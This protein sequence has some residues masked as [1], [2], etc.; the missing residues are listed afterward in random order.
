[1]LNI[2]PV[3]S[4]HCLIIALLSLLT[5]GLFNASFAA[6][7]S[8]TISGGSTPLENIKVSLL[9][10]NQQLIPNVSTVTTDVTGTYNFSDIAEGM[11]FITVTAPSNSLYSDPTPSQITLA[12]DNQTL[13][14][15]LSLKEVLLEGLVH[16]GENN[17]LIGATITVFEK[18]G[19]SFQQRGEAYTVD[20]FGRYQ[21]TL[22]A[23]QYFLRSNVRNSQSTREGI[24][25]F[26]QYSSADF[27]L[28]QNTTLDIEFPFVAISG[29]V[30]DA[31]GLP[32]VGAQLTT[33]KGWQ[34]PSQGPS[35]TLEQRSLNHLNES[36]VTNSN[37]EYTLL[38]YPSDLCIDAAFF[39]DPNDCLYDI[40]VVPPANSGFSEQQQI[41][42]EVFE[43][44]NLNFVLGMSS[45]LAPKIVAGPFAESISDSAATITWRSDLASTGVVNITGLGQFTSDQ[46]ATRHQV[47]VNSL[48]ANSSYGYTVTATNEAGLSSA[49]HSGSFTT[50]ATPDTLPP[51]FITSPALTLI[52][53]TSV[54]IHF[55]ANEAVTGTI[56]LLNS[57]S[58][59]SNSF[60]LDGYNTCFDTRI[61]QLTTNTA[62]SFVVSITDLAE[63]GPTQS[64]ERVFK[65]LTQTDTIAPQIITGPFVTNISNRSALVRWTTDEPATSGVTLTKGSSHQVITDSELTREHTVLFSSLTAASEYSV[66]VTSQDADGNGPSV[67]DSLTFSTKSIPDTT[68]PFILGQPLVLEVTSTTATILWRS[69]E[70][71]TGVI[72]LG[73]RGESR[74]TVFSSTSI[75]N[76]HNVAVT[77]LSA[78]TQYDFQVEVTDLAGLTTQSQILSFKTPV[79]DIRV[80][81]EI[82]AGPTVERVTHNSL[83]VSWRTATP[84][85]PRLVCQAN[86]QIREVEKV[87]LATSHRLTISG[88]E[89]STGYQ[90]SIFATDSLGLSTNANFA[91]GTRLPIADTQSPSCTAPPQ[92]AGLGLSAEVTWESDEAST[93]VIHWR[94][95]SDEQWSEVSSE[96]LTTEHFQ[97]VS[98]LSSNTEYDVLIELTDVAG[99]TGTCGEGSF[100]SGD[101]QPD[102]VFT[103]A[104]TIETVDHESAVVVWQTELNSTGQI[105]Y[106]L[107][108]ES[109]DL[110]RASDEASRNHRSKLTKLIANTTYYLRVIAANSEGDL[111]ESAVISFTTKALPPVAPTLLAGPNVVD[112]TDSS[113]VVEWQTDKATIGLVEIEGIGQFENF[114]STTQHQI[115][116]N[117]LAPSTT[118]VASVIATD[119]FGLSCERTSVEFTTSALPDTTAPVF[120]SGPALSSVATTSAVVDFCADEPVTGQLILGDI[121]FDLDELK[122]CHTINLSGLQQSTQYAFRCQIR[123]GAG[124]GPTESQSLSFTTQTF[125]DTTAPAILA[126]PIVSQITSQSAIVTW[127]TSEA[128]SSQV[129]YSDGVS[130]WQVAENNGVTD[131]QILL[132]GLSASTTYSLTVASSDRLGN[133]PTVSEAV[134]FTTLG[135]PDTAAPQIIFGPE[136]QDITLTS[137]YVIWETNEAATSLVRFGLSA[138]SLDLSVS[139]GD[140]K[141]SHKLALTQLSPATEYFGQVESKDAAGNAAQSEV[142][143]FKTLTPVPGLPVIPK[144][145]IIDG[146]RIDKVTH[147]SMT[148]S[149]ETNVNTDSR[150]VC[151]R[152]GNQHET[153]DSEKAQKHQLTLSGL[154][155][156]TRYQCEVFSTDIHQQTVSATLAGTCDGRPDTTAPQ[157]LGPVEVLSFEDEA[158][159]TWTSDEIAIATI[160]YR[161]QG[162]SE[163]LEAS[164]LDPVT[165]GYRRLSDLATTTTY[166]LQVQLSDQSGNKA[167]C[168]VSTFLSGG[169]AVLPLCQFTIQP[170][171]SNIGHYS[172]EVNWTTDSLSTGIVHF[173]LASSELD[174]REA[175]NETSRNH[176]VAL[177]SLTPNTTYYVQVEARNGQGEANFSQVVAFTT[178]APEP[179]SDGDTIPEPPVVTIPVDENPEDPVVIEFDNCP[180][181]ANEDQLDFDGDGIGDA[182][183]NDDDND[184]CLDTEDDFPL[185]PLECRDLDNDG[186]GNNSDPDDDGDNIVDIIDDF[187]LDP[188]PVI[189]GIVTGEGKAIEGALVS[190]YDSESKVVRSQLTTST[191]DYRFEGLPSGSYFVGVTPPSSSPF[192]ATPLQAITLLDRNVR[193]LISLVGDAITVS[194]YLKD[195]AGRSIDGVQI[196]L[197]QQDSGNQVGNRILTDETGYFEFGVAPGTY[198]LKPHIDILGRDNSADEANENGV[199]A[200]NYPVPDYA[201]VFYLVNNIQV[202]ENTEIEAVIPMAFISGQT[203]DSNGNAIAGVAIGVQHQYSNN[204]QDFYLETY[205]T[206]EQS[207]SRS[208]ANG[209]FRFALFTGQVVD[210]VLTPP[211]DRTDLGARI[212]KNFSL[213]EDKTEN[214]VLITGSIL[215]GQVSDSANRAIDFAK[216]SLHDQVSGKQVGKAVYSDNTGSFRFQVEDGTYQI[217]VQ[218]DP[219]GNLE[220]GAAGRPNYPVADFGLVEFAQENIVVA[221]SS[222]VQ[223]QLPMAILTG[224]VIDANNS[225]Q[226]QVRV[227]ISHNQ[228]VGGQHY[229][230]E[231]Q[232]V[233]EH[234]NAITDSEGQF[235]LALFTNQATQLILSPVDRRSDQASTIIQDF[236][237]VGD[238]TQTF[239]LNEAL[240]LSGYL[241][242]NENNPIDNTMITAHDVVS[243]QRVGAVAFTDNNGYFAIKVAPGNYKLRPYLQPRNPLGNGQS[244]P[245]YPV[246]DYAAVYYLPNNIEVLADT[247]INVTVPMSILTGEAIDENG[248]AVPQVK[249]QADHNFSSEDTS[250]YLEN[251]GDSFGSNAISDESGFFNFALFTNQD[252]DISVVPPEGSG[253][254]ITR[255]QHKLTQETLEDVILQHVDPV[256]PSIIAGPF[257]SNITDNTALVTWETDKPCQGSLFLDGNLVASL[258][259]FSL[260]HNVVLESLSAQSEYL[261]EAHCQD[262]HELNAEPKSTSFITD[263]KPDTSA[264]NFILGPLVNSISHN[265]FTYGFCADEPVTGRVFLDGE[266]IVLEHLAICHQLVIDNRL[267]GT[268][269]ALQ[270]EI[271]DAAGNG[272]TQS[273]ILTVTTLLEPDTTKPFILGTPMVIDISDTQATVIWKTNE[274]A[275]SGVSYND[276][277]QYHVASSADLVTEHV[278][279][280]TDLTPETRYTLTVS[281]TDKYGN[282]PALSAPLDFTT[283]AA[284]DTTAPIL[285]GAPIIQNLTHQNVVI[286]WGTHEA[287]TTQL[288]MGLSPDDLSEAKSRQGMSQFHNVAVSGLE[289]DQTFYFQAVSSDA[290]GNTTYS[291][292]YSF[293][294]NIKPNECREHFKQPAIVTQNTG[295]SLVIE[296]ETTSNTQGRVVC[297]SS[298]DTVELNSSE[299]TRK[300]QVVFT[301]LERDTDYACVVHATDNQGLVSSTPVYSEYDET[302]FDFA[303]HSSMCQKGPN[304]I[305]G[306]GVA[307]IRTRNDL[308]SAAPKFSQT[309]QIVGL[310]QFATIDFTTNELTMAEIEYRRQGTSRWSRTGTTLAKFT[311]GIALST[312]KANTD[313]ELRIVLTDLNSN[314]TLSSTFYFN[315][316][317]DNAT[318]ALEFTATPS[319]VD[320]EFDT[321]LVQWSSSEYSSGQVE[322]GTHPER[323]NRTEGS[324]VL[325]RNHQVR[326][327]TLSP[328]TAYYL[329]V[330]AFDLYGN[331]YTSEVIQFYT[332]AFNATDDSDGDGMTDAYELAQGL[333][334][335]DAS[336]A[337]IDSDNDGLTNREEYIAQTDPNASD[338][339]GDGILD[340]WEIDRGLDPNDASDAAQDNGNGQSYLDE[341]LGASDTEAPIITL[342][343]SVTINATG[344]KT[345]IPSAGVS[346]TDNIDGS[347]AVTLEGATHV[348]PGRHV[349]IWRAQDSAGN[350]S[351]VLQTVNVLP[352]VLVKSKQVVAE[353]QIAEVRVRLSGE[354]PFYP[355]EIPFNLSTNSNENGMA[356]EQDVVTLQDSIRITSGLEGSLAIAV[357]T[358]DETEGE[359]SL[360][361]SFDTPV[362]ATLGS[363]QQH[364]IFIIEDNAA[365]QVSLAAEQMGEPAT[366]ILR[367][368]GLVEIAATIED[369]NSQDSHTLTWDRLNSTVS[370][371]DDNASTLT[372][373]PSTLAEGIYDVIVTVADNGTPALTTETTLRIKV[374]ASAPVLSANFDS[375][376]DGISDADEGFKDSDQDG[377]PDY[378]DAIEQSNVLQTQLGEA[379]GDDPVFLMETEPGLRLSLGDVALTLDEGGTQI[380]SESLASNENYDEF[381]SDEQFDNIGGLYN[382][383]IHGLGKIG[384]SVRL[385]IPQAQALPA[386]AV[387]RKLFSDSGWRDFQVDENNHLYSAAGQEGRC[388]SPGDGAYT[389]GLTAGHWC[390]MMLI[391]DG[392][393][394]D[395]DGLANGSIVDP[396]GVGTPKAEEADPAPQPTPE[397]PATD[398]PASSGGGGSIGYFMLCLLVLRRR[399]HTK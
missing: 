159:V 112:I 111:T 176:Q 227:Q 2:R 203:L 128:A 211:G 62:Y 97:I 1:M 107:S 374:A 371:L 172:A 305:N 200:P 151:H 328:A 388:P 265:E 132:T 312:L 204:D 123:D 17:P 57:D 228:Q 283:L 273:P 301:D 219:L 269:Y 90:C 349:V 182:C 387:Y 206:A 291:D 289:S 261:V 15:S 117:G 326:L 288:L 40:T 168:G 350:A 307:K 108:T 380:D 360:V 290:A 383:E 11:Y 304:S 237:L 149:W 8:G 365:P 194:G 377:I 230:L 299:S 18:L 361:V 280:L 69:D 209:Q 180:N 397:P 229:L 240:T 9:D 276:G 7:I 142:F 297:A 161:A 329:R 251:F 218:L 147:N 34:G 320:L 190:V 35:G 55:C 28:T 233:I 48:T 178:T 215:N 354:A 193:Y 231:T 232:G 109:L 214:F 24:P 173:G 212:V 16:D 241:K 113:A 116:V 222:S 139:D 76:H 284:A 258:E 144:P 298:T 154:Q 37:G 19:G 153:S 21:M 3:N 292:I 224:K 342:E 271:V 74:D 372:F 257:I 202:S 247:E 99:N 81:P 186:I 122:S 239:V 309:P 67:S 303:A 205:G 184:G 43:N 164:D 343:N 201:G 152:D 272:P 32:I 115:P 390:V 143:R 30:V 197:H 181:V 71:T 333:D 213:N 163:W 285:M 330:K 234:S 293:T 160:Q 120:I 70:A 318:A 12:N 335:Q 338:S 86:E 189:S 39:I 334:P 207:Y 121:T 56:E 286:R 84:T 345:A 274:M 281:S 167:S 179:D 278:M 389:E 225:P 41:D 321:A 148:V 59:S 103:L 348:S 313:Y 325:G 244:G 399:T 54:S 187:P 85:T 87:D 82:V 26:A 136:V 282:G 13:N 83:T 337:D 368:G 373:D 93:A 61:D 394:N 268:E 78:N 5:S 104:P 327:N 162:E 376:G 75:Q 133:G 36:A 135:L 302:R 359:E 223:V 250:Y 44:Q 125:V 60:P 242:D 344:P 317:E 145:I 4:L 199:S 249:L 396:G 10:E 49:Q 217:K 141:S 155:A 255:V 339:D 150:L 221:G 395:A 391:E 378:L 127:Q 246:P 331:S 363:N 357:L 47:V 236:T 175:T 80:K 369:P 88:L 169:I 198:K 130:S 352:Q 134:S 65:T 306:Q 252:I 53:D 68:P 22:T 77:G 185:N 311:H 385:V 42:Y 118:Y 119:R 166:E 51:Q 102:P 191:G 46:L 146:P 170:V 171:I 89:V 94:L 347:V 156:S 110:S 52:Q 375:D 101:G 353:G 64:V 253:F 346:A 382:F 256:A 393:P 177:D 277:S 98:G 138:E 398:A 245:S 294:T 314:S 174:Q 386:N 259:R 210:L 248:V 188:G 129:D 392:G 340:G 243:H 275:T 308:D 50:K 31:N 27:E 25:N 323:L 20:S 124:N 364:E 235:Q 79:A 195:N 370:D 95:A 266:T 72:S 267:P 91:A 316:G 216:I 332:P 14:F 66:V 158:E 126:G 366:L 58:G 351:S 264:P 300:H 196:S 295:I 45:P 310:G 96:N 381:A 384:D 262:K 23:G 324:E 63:N 105:F 114:T 192:R 106:G 287:A 208:D 137:A 362:N 92:I 260:L 279:H 254:A 355:I 140:L 322:F 220:L 336:D 315:S 38:L 165:E 6:S 270:A 183:D 29:S 73:A 379:S 100:N 263:T 131:H 341:Y 319:I 296:W 157:C 356:D 33:S 367:D 238:A 226:A 358:D